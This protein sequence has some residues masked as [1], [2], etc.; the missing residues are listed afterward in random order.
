MD[1]I[2]LAMCKP[3]VINLSAYGDGSTSVETAL[4]VL[5]GQG[6]GSV[7]IPN[8][9]NFWNDVSTDKQLVLT[10]MFG[11]D[12]LVFSGFSVARFETKAWQVA[13]TMTMFNPQ[14]GLMTIAIALSRTSTD[15]DNGMTVT[16]Q[17]S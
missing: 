13:W 17:I 6:G 7:T 8:V 3:K 1:L 10:M 12:E 9:G 5:I 14:A 11:T 4:M 15:G 2:T 16:V